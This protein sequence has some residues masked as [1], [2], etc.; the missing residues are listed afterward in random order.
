MGS[1][2]L[3][4]KIAA[5]KEKIEEIAKQQ[6]KVCLVMF[7][8]ACIVQA[9]VHSISWSDT[10]EIS[11]KNF[12]VL[13]F[14]LV[15]HMYIYMFGCINSIMGRGTFLHAHLGISKAHAEKLKLCSYMQTCVQQ[16][17]QLLVTCRLVF[18]RNCSCVVTCRLV[19]SRNCSCVAIYTDL[20]SPRKCS[21]VYTCRLVFR[22]YTASV[23]PE[24]KSA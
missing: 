14:G 15:Y 10:M 18:S 23:P 11:F 9:H 17:L 19:F 24:H 2:L 7:K 1:P 21:C 8:H 22:M 6:Q 12:F 5:E 4:G 3:D 20:F 16:E 13:L